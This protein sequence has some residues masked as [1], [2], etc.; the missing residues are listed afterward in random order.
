MTAPSAKYNQLKFG[1]GETKVTVEMTGE[2]DK[3]DEIEL[4]FYYTIID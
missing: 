2:G 1:D 4:E 3:Y